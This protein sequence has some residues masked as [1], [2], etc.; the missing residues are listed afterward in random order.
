MYD[1]RLD[2]F[3]AA[4]D[5]GS[6]TKAAE[7]LFISATAVTKQIN[8]LES[9]TGLHLFQRTRHGVIL[10][11]SGRAFYED[12]K[13]IIRCAQDAVARARRLEIPAENCI[14][15]GTSPL[16]SDRHLHCLWTK[17][18]AAEPGLRIHLVPFDDTYRQYQQTLERLGEEIDVIASTYSPRQHGE[19]YSV[20]HIYDSPLCCSMPRIHPLAS[21]EILTPQDLFGE[22]LMILRRG[23]SPYIDAARD[24][25]ETY[26]QIHLL[27]VP[28]YEMDTFNQCAAS[29][30]LLLSNTVW[31]SIHTT[32]VTIPVDWS[33]TV[34]YGLLY[35]RH[36]SEA[37]QRFIE[38]AEK[39]LPQSL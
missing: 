10:T 12:A 17:I 22:N 21:R 4:A 13:F 2:T 11:D 1:K 24:T 27:D 25:L 5:T 23:G 6:F 26:P 20:L 33:Y 19:K 9:E 14:R 39:F 35:S 38:L 28:D 3:L 29:G 37:V 30:S 15:I 8:T 16:R 32:L 7:Q 34:P 36:P 31:A 18:Q